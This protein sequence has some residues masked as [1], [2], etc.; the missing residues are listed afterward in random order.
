MLF[1]AQIKHEAI[2]K[3]IILMK[4]GLKISSIDNQLGKNEIRDR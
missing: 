2:Y 4:L 1:Y 3:K